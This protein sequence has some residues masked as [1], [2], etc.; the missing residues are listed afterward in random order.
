LRASTDLFDVR[1][2]VAIWSEANVALTA[3]ES[4]V[5]KKDFIVSRCHREMVELPKILVPGIP[6][7]LKAYRT[8]KI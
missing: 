8:A 5:Y 1:C 2:L 4:A 7:A 3:I 6:R